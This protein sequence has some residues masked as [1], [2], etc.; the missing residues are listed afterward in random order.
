MRKWILITTGIVI[1]FV[2]VNGI[3]SAHKIPLAKCLDY[4]Y[5]V[6]FV[7]GELPIEMEFFIDD[8]LFKRD[9]ADKR[10]KSTLLHCGHD[11]KAVFSSEG[12][13]DVEVFIPVPE[14]NPIIYP[15]V[16]VEIK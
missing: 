14:Y 15:T 11:Y 16:E 2:I 12:Y 10:F 3:Q 9:T 7:G 4:D 8:E 1:L 5:K 6:E 13:D